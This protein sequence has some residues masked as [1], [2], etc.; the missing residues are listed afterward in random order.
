MHRTLSL[1]TLYS[2]V[3]T[4]KVGCETG[5]RKQ[6]GQEEVDDISTFFSPRWWD[7]IREVHN[8]VDHW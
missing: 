5:A 7:L 2:L 6:A 8:S 3:T 4:F 1:Y